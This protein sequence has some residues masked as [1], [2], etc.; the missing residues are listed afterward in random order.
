M[1]VEGCSWHITCDHEMNRNSEHLTGSLKVRA[2]PNFQSSLIPPF[3]KKLSVSLQ[4][5]QFSSNQT[6]PSFISKRW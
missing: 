5:K 2:G 3:R 1:F 4:S 6:V